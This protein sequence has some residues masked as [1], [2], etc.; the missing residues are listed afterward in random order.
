MPPSLSSAKCR[1][2]GTHGQSGPTTTT[3]TFWVFM[4]TQPRKVSDPSFTRHTTVVVE[5]CTVCLC[6]SLPGGNPSID[7]IIDDSIIGSFPF[8][9][10]PPSPLYSGVHL[11]ATDQTPVFLIITSHW[12]VR[13]FTIGTGLFL[14]IRDFVRTVLLMWRWWGEVALG[15]KSKQGVV[16]A[17]FGWKQ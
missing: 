5:Y 9:H 1:P 14:C 17:V 8:P 11:C 10:S 2:H 4:L 15:C 12:S 3:T 6:E 7:A 16:V 13:F